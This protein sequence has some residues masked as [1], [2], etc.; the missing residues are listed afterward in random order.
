[1]D[2]SFGIMPALSWQ[3][4]LDRLISSKNNNLWDSDVPNEES[5]FAVVDRL[6]CLRSKPITSS[7][8]SEETPL[9]N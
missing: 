8:L 2:T 9:L 7:K 4:F 3:P 5:K 1:M 6:L